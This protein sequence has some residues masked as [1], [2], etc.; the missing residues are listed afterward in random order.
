MK[1]EGDAGAG[2]DVGVEGEGAADGEL[3]SD[4]GGGS[5]E[6]TSVEV[7]SA[8]PEVEVAA[9]PVMVPTVRVKLA[10]TIEW[11]ELGVGAD[12]ITV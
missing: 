7:D 12:S 11:L 3:G 4:P 10:V 9:V 5:A 2:A 8:D 1:T 6:G